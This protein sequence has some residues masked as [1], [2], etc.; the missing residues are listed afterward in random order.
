[1]TTDLLDEFPDPVQQVREARKEIAQRFH[2]DLQAI[3]SDASARE[4][5]HPERLAPLTPAKPL[6]KG[7]ESKIA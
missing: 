4:Q 3:V 6:L 2:F 5:K 7:V 1:M